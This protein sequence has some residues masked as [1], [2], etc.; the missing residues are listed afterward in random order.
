[1]SGVAEE[2]RASGQDAR[3]SFARRVSSG[4]VWNQLSRII[5]IAAA[6]VASVLIARGLGPVE[7]GTYSVALSMVTFTYFA[8][9]LGMNEVLNVHVPRLGDAPAQVAF[10]LRALLKLR[11]VIALGLAVAMFALAPLLASLYHSPPL[12]TVLRAAALYVFFYNVML[13]L[14]YFLV[15]ALQVPRVARARIMVQVLNLAAAAAALRWHWHAWPLFLTM[16]GSSALGLAWLSWGARAALLGASERFDLTPLRRFGLTLWVTNFV[17]F[18]L[19]RQADILMIGYFRPN[20]DQAGCYSVAA[21]LAML[22][23]S[24]LLLGTEGVSLAAFSDIDQRIG[25]ESVGRLWNLHIKIDLLLSVPLLLLGGL[26]SGPIISV[27]YK[28]GYEHAAPMLTAYVV[29]WA[30]TRALGGGTNMTVLYAMNQPRIPLIIYGCSGA[31]NLLANLWL[32]HRWGALGA[33]LGTGLAMAGSSVA[34]AS[35]LMRRTGAR[36]P[37]DLMLKLAVA[38]LPVVIVV[39]AL[40]LPPGIGGLMVQA[41]AGAIA[42]L[43]AVRLLKPFNESDRNLLSRLN[44][45]V[46][47]LAS[48]L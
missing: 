2:A 48:W 43:A 7:F 44:P 32:V 22:C 37:W 3:S 8:T 38:S 12:G 17:N 40:R 39:R 9:S 5:E 15:G 27:L 28:S 14:E 47:R 13:L 29:V 11:S 31:F 25:R 20:T 41:G 4:L 18:F 46:G 16:A 6:Y 35:L 36:L 23:A 1:M 26:L 30:I 42:Y 19:G 10:L 21:M 24:A 34:S 33:I 45:R